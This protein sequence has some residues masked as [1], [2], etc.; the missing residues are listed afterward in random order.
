MNNNL[1]LSFYGGAGIT[2]KKQQQIKQNHQLFL[3]TVASQHWD[4]LNEAVLG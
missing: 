1:K 2:P 4:E 3:D